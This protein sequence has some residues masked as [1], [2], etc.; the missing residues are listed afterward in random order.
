M[1]ISKG[2]NRFKVLNTATLGAFEI[3]MNKYGLK[4]GIK[5]FMALQ[6]AGGY[7]GNVLTGSVNF[8][9]VK[10]YAR[11]HFDWTCSTNEFFLTEEYQNARKALK[12]AIVAGNLEAQEAAKAHMEAIKN[13]KT[14]LIDA[15]VQDGQ[16]YINVRVFAELFLKR[17]G[18]H[19]DPRALVGLLF[20][21]RPT[22]AKASALG[23]DEDVFNQIV[24][25]TC[26]MAG[27]KLR[28]VK[29]IISKKLASGEYTQEE[30]TKKIQEAEAEY[31]V[32]FI[33]DRNNLL[34]IG[35]KHC[36]K[37]DYDMS[38]T[39]TFEILAMSKCST[40]RTSKQFAETILYAAQQ[41]GIDGAKLLQNIM[42]LSITANLKSKIFERKAH[43]P[44][45][46]EVEDSQRSGFFNDLIAAISPEFIMQNKA[47]FN[48]VVRQSINSD[49]NAIDGLN[50]SI[51]S[52]NRR[53]VSDFTFLITN[54]KL[55]GI[56]KTGE[57]FINSRKISKVVMIKYPKMGLREFYFAKNV[58]LK[59]I[60]NRIDFAVK[61]HIITKHEGALLYKAFKNIDNYLAVLPARMTTACAC[62]G[63]DYDY[64][65]S[66]FVEY[67]SN[68][69]EDDITAK[70]TNELIE[71]LEQTKMKA[72]VIL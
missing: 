50:G 65:G 42:E 12:D 51:I 45:P 4:G 18:L 66:L 55:H 59:E 22:T 32:T 39:V 64:D 2:D 6:K 19:V 23:M 58:S 14:L 72:V 48:S 37:L 11:A 68:P 26:H 61:K 28:L 1:D 31:K 5:T 15:D 40:S 17:F 9:V 36:F 25:V 16:M 57:V 3:L 49:V 7:I 56:L 41:L 63:L 71:I 29:A 13:A 33:G 52:H 30:A 47:L 35:D 10:N 24:D 46:E 62:A 69:A 8:G 54:C 43:I 21:A 20:Q 34:F 53:L 70:L 38:K 44:T 60:K 27:T 67:T